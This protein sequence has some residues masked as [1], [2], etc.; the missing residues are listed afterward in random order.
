LGIKVGSSQEPVELRGLAGIT[1]DMITEGTQKK[2][3]KEIAEEIDFIGGGLK[4]GSDFDFTLIIGSAL[5]GYTDR[6]MDVISD[7][8][9]NPS[10]PEDEL[11]LKKTNL[12]Q[13]LAMKRSEPDFLQDE[14]FSQVVY[15]QHPY[16]V[17]APSPE[18]VE[19]ITRKDLQD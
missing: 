2:S 4:G 9:L 8:V 15:G 10:F 3:S 12:L 7:V 1:A 16:S 11:K 17:V 5:S 18:N 14:R 6:L 19:K 13:E